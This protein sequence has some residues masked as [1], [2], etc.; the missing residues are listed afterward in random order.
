MADGAQIKIIG[1]AR[2]NATL[3]AAARQISNPVEASRK[4]ATLVER[5]GRQ[6]APKRSG[7]LSRSIV[8]RPKTG[9]A[10]IG[11]SLVYAGVIH[12]G[13]PRHHITANPYLTRALDSTQDQVVSVY[14]QDAQRALDHVQGA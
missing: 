1:G 9:G 13:W 11:S 6:N 12:N 4:A 3:D 14:A 2:L 8:G 5:Q 7:R 10:E